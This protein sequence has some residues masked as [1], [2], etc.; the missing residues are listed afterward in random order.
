MRITSVNVARPG[1]VNIKGKSVKTGIFKSPVEGS[2]WIGFNGL[3]EDTRVE[4][5][6][7]GELNHA[8]HIYA[9]ENYD[10][11]APRLD[12]ASLP[13]GF[14]GENLTA[15]G[16]LETEIRIGD[17]LQ[18]GE[19]LLRVT[20][21]RIPCRKLDARVGR[22]FSRLFLESRRVG[23]YLKVVKEGAVCAGD[24]V[25]LL[26]S[27][28]EAVTLAEFTRLTSFD[29]WDVEGLERVLAMRH[30][31]DEWREMIE[32]KLAR[33]RRTDGWFGL[34]SFEVVKKE[35]LRED[36]V[37]LSLRCAL[38]KPLP[39]F[40]G[41]QSLV[42]SIRVT[43]DAPLRRRAY[44]ISNNPD[45]VDHYRITV[46]RRTGVA[47]LPDGVISTYLLRDVVVG[48]VLRASAPRGH[49]TLARV[50]PGCEQIIIVSEAIGV[51]PAVALLHEWSKL[52]QRPAIVF[53]HHDV[54]GQ[55]VLLDE[56]YDIAMRQ[57]GE[58]SLVLDEKISTPDR[59]REQTVVFQREDFAEQL[60]GLVRSPLDSIFL[61]G[62]SVF[63]KNLA[64]GL[65]ER[66]VQQ[67]QLHL[68]RFGR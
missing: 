46:Q 48:D 61:V 34:R 32:D 20:Q 14:F 30:L 28:P 17:L 11:W 65:I 26:E 10:Y 58:V 66:G 2:H 13:S 25:R 3:V 45:E 27:D 50:S 41:G 15:E 62:Q 47:D 42:F 57:A 16:L 37:S 59:L 38:G 49:F 39:Q 63:I 67:E 64:D 33:A 60:S 6:K 53:C 54:G 29:Y 19:A 24:E 5:R 23:F 56:V 36:V 12:R 8:V 52:A 40:R 68:E 7:F 18:V 22:K 1:V 21:P 55:P 35:S 31:V 44:A 43:P 4:P 51:A 9:Q